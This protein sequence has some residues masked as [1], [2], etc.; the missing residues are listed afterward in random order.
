MPRTSSWKRKMRKSKISRVLQLKISHLFPWTRSIQAKCLWTTA[1][2]WTRALR[3]RAW[4]AFKNLPQIPL[5]TKF[6]SL[7][8]LKIKL[9][10]PRFSQ[11]KCQWSDLLCTLKLKTNLSKPSW[12][13]RMRTLWRSLATKWTPREEPPTFGCTQ[14]IQMAVILLLKMLIPVENLSSNCYLTT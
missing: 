10:R 9:S 3:T 12:L 7:S 4:V 6:K 13:T 5:Q 2:Q 11:S 14:T 8:S 1:C